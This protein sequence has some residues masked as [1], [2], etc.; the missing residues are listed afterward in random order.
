MMIRKNLRKIME[1]FLL[2]FSMLKK[3]KHKSDRGKTSYSFN[4]SK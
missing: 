4:D 3:K 2:M 1:L